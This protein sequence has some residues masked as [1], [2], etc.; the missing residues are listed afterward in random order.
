MPDVV[1]ADCD[2]DVLAA[3]EVKHKDVIQ[4]SLLL[5]TVKS[6]SSV[7]VDTNLKDEQAL[8]FHTVCILGFTGSLVL[9]VQRL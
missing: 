9:N 4:T 8:L 3:I 1:P 2:E 7:L 6:V 5:S